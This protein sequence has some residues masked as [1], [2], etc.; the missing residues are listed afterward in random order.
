MVFGT[1]QRTLKYKTDDAKSKEIYIILDNTYLEKVN[2]TKFL[3]VVVDEH[4]TWKY[5]IDG[6]TKTMSRNYGVINKMK[7]EF[8]N[9][10]FIH[11]TVLL[12]YHI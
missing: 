2:K 6:L 1:P 11:F 10:Y 4:L 7:H 9:V 5:H 12:Y 8:L 3:G